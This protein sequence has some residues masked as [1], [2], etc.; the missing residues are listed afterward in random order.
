MIDK[1]IFNPQI[2]FSNLNLFKP[3]PTSL[4]SWK[5]RKEVINWGI[6]ISQSSNFKLERIKKPVQT[7]PPSRLKFEKMEAKG[8]NRDISTLAIHNLQIRTHSNLL[9]RDFGKWK[10]EVNR[11]ILN[12]RLL[13]QTNSNPISPILSQLPS[14][15]GKTE[16]VINWDISTPQA[17]TQTNSLNPF[18]F[19]PSQIEKRKEEVN[20]DIRKPFQP[21]RIESRK[22]GREDQ[23]GYIRF[24]NPQFKQTF[25][26]PFNFPFKLKKGKKRS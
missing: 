2:Q 23:L 3:F 1:G 17:T 5:T 9:D 24:R 6:S 13:I 25:S 16:R 11:D 20:R 22:K 10:K 14:K 18:N 7:L 21:F 19:P 4:S 12:S 15:T 8:L 26:N